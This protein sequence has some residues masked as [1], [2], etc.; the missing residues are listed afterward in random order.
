MVTNMMKQGCSHNDDNR[1]FTHAHCHKPINR[2][3]SIHKKSVFSVREK[4]ARPLK[5]NPFQR[6]E[7]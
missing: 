5:G 4:V 7:L 6:V 3:K 1:V 2:N